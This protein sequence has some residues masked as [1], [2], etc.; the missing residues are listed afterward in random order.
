MIY[1]IIFIYLFALSFYYDVLGYRS[2]NSLTYNLYFLASLCILILV[3]G[4]RYRLGADTYLYM[5]YYNHHCHDLFHLT[6]YDLSG[7]IYGYEPLW[8]ILNSFCKTFTND[9]WPVQLIVSTFHISAWGYFVKKICPSYCFLMLVF[10]FLFEWFHMDFVLMREAIA[11]GLFLLAVL[12]LNSKRYLQMLFFIVVSFFFHKFSVLIFLAF[13]L[14]YKLLSRDLRLGYTL[15]FFMMFLG[16]IYD[17]WV[18]EIIGRFIGIDSMYAQRLS[19]YMNSDYYGSSSLNWK[20]RLVLYAS[21][22]FYLYVLRKMRYEIATYVRL[23]RRI[24]E[25]A[26]IMGAAILTIKDSVLIFYRVYDYFHTFTSMISVVFLV[27]VAKSNFFYRYKIVW[28][29]VFML[30]PMRFFYSSYINA[31]WGGQDYVKRIREFVP[32][33]S[34]LFPEKDPVRESRIFNTRRIK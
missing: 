26:I 18:W 23:D 28:F 17:G 8:V 7:G 33:S 14:Y 21:I 1:I 31:Q 29:I 3:S 34:V 16:L 2:H 6:S 15:V 22:G 25:T 27:S 30:I 20:G 9:F 19:A 4:L 5:I 10:F 12:S 13:F 24:V 11:L 32:Y